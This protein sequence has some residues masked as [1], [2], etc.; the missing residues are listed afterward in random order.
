V[1]LGALCSSPS[2][3]EVTPEL[4]DAVTPEDMRAGNQRHA[5]ISSLHGVVF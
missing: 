5:G 3:N 2:L 4:A 1:A